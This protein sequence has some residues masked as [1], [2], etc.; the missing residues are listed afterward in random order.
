M[1][2]SQGAFA[3]GQ[4]YVAISRVTRPLDV[5]AAF[6]PLQGAAH[7]LVLDL[8]PALGKAA[9]I[10]RGGLAAEASDFAGRLAAQCVKKSNC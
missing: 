3:A 5:A 9:R 1:D 10:R 7:G 6:Q 8:N 2:L 4:A